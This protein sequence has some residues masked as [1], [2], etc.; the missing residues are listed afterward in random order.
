M[1]IE[2]LIRRGE[3]ITGDG[4]AI[5]FLGTAGASGYAANQIDTIATAKAIG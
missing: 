2:E 4:R 1:I 3:N 5:E